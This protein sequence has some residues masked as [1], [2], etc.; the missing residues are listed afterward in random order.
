[1]LTIENSALYEY[2][3]DINREELKKISENLKNKYN[4]VITFGFYEETS[5]YKYEALK[6]NNGDK[7]I[8][9]E[10]NKKR[11]IFPITITGEIYEYHIKAK[12]AIYPKLYRILKYNNNDELFES[13]I[14]WKNTNKDS[15]YF[16][17]YEKNDLL[18]EIIKYINIE[19]I[20]LLN[21]DVVNTLAKLDYNEINYKFLELIPK[22]E[23]NYKFIKNVILKEKNNK[24]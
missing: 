23:K 12:V 21:A 22:F 18:Q 13:L 19:K 1:M 24:K 2:K 9:I 4:K 6:R 15:E 5:N 8:S 14:N 16:K 7:I 17:N 3:V 20:L 11:S 10:V